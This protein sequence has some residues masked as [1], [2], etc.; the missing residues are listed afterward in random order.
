V[1]GISGRHV[2]TQPQ[3]RFRFYGQFC[4]EKGKENENAD[5]FFGRKIKCRKIKKHA[6]SGTE[7]EKENE[8]RSASTTEGRRLS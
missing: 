5:I 2:L 1:N 3:F 7:K 6:F 8:I 4:T